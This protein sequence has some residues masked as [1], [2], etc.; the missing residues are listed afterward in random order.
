M[1]PEVLRKIEPH[2]CILHGWQGLPEEL[3][4]DLDIVVAPESLPDLEKELLNARSGKLVQLLQH[5]SSCYYFVLAVE[6]ENCLKFIPI[7]TATDYRRD[8]RVFFTAEELL[9]GRRAWNGFWVASPQVEFGYLLVKKVLKADFPEHQKKRFKELLEELGGEAEQ[10]ADRFFGNRWGREVIGWIR[11][12]DWQALEKRLPRVR[13][14]LLWRKV[15]QDPLNPLRYWIPEMGRILRRWRHPTGLVVVV[16][17]PDGAG[18]STLVDNLQEQLQ[19]PFRRTA[20]LHFK[21][22]LFGK[23]GPGAPVTDPHGKPPRSLPASIAKLAYYLASYLL[24]YWLRI[25]PL[26]VK[27]TL[28]LFD[29]YYDDLLV[30]PRR[31]RYG[32]PMWLA[33]FVQR[34]I[35]R[36]DLFLILDVP[37]QQLVARK[38]EVPWEEL[39]RQR[40]AYRRLAEA[41]PNA[42]LVDGSLPAEAVAQNAREIVLDFLHERYLKRRKIWFGKE[43]PALDWLFSVLNVKP[44][45]SQGI[46]FGKL[47]LPDGRGY[48]VPL[49]HSRKVAARSLSIYSAQGTK[50]KLAKGVLEAGFCLGVCRWLLPKVELDVL[51]N[52]GQDPSLLAFL[53]NLFGRSD[54]AF[55][56][57]LGTPGPHRKPTIQVL[58]PDGQ[59]LGYAKVGWNENTRCLIENERKALEIFNNSLFRY[60]A[61]P[62]VLYYGEWNGKLLLIT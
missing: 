38:R 61:F 37:E 32:A 48:L 56:I 33:H 49:S 12:E 25:R 4:S 41:L 10:I 23:K 54:L 24:G 1:F 30:D 6:N 21:P 42:I 22:R 43:A 14:V 60:S 3:P 26:L 62:K 17:G 19:G 27:S 28:V 15:R 34:R 47:L 36:P 40:E 55:A 45:R 58:A 11:T 13:R 52:G 5:E 53:Q 50:A 46:P 51:G 59:I 39:G 16:L 7:D 29:R 8:G 44:G 20:V 2:Y 18:K 31:Y 35:Q 57:S 9:A